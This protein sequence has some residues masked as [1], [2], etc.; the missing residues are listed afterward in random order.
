MDNNLV[1]CNSVNVDERN[2][3]IRPGSSLNN[4]RD[5]ADNFGQ[6]SFEEVK[7]EQPRNRSRSASSAS[8]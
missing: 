4:L 7:V 6:H 8:S 5:L 3:R 2:P 1:R